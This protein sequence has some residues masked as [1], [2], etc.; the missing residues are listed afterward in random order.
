MV[1][2][3]GVEKQRE[4]GPPEELSREEEAAIREEMRQKLLEQEE[5]TE[6]EVAHQESERRRLMESER[7][8]WRVIEEETERFHGEHGRVRYVSS[9]GKVLWLTPEQVAQ[10][11]ARKSK[12]RRRDKRASARRQPKKWAALQ[13][14]TMLG[15]IIISLCVVVFIAVIIFATEFL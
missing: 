4:P 12:S 14:K 3:G 5:E 6:R 7:L 8:R 15:S 13:L 9:S 10:R 11:R 2:G 1:R